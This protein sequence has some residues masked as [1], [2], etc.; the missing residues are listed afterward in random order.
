MK[1]A[2]VN[3]DGNISP[4]DAIQNL[5]FYFSN[6]SEAPAKAFWGEMEEKQPE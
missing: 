6:D 3:Q 1:A 5:L 4:A 2:D